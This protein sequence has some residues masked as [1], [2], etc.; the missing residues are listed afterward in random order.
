MSVITISIILVSLAITLGVCG[1]FFGF[2][3]FIG[4]GIG[5]VMAVALVAFFEG[6][7]L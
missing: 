7:H 5:Y 1:A 4:W 2:G 6:E 3:V